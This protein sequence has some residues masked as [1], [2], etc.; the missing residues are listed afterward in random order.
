MSQKI[1]TVKIVDQL[2]TELN[3]ELKIDEYGDIN[4][5]IFIRDEI[6]YVDPKGH[7]LKKR[8]T[9]VLQG[10]IGCRKCT[11][12]YNIK[13]VRKLFSD[14]GCELLT[15]VY[16]DSKEQQFSYLCPN[17]H[18][19]TT[20]L[21]NF[22]HRKSYECEECRKDYY[23]NEI[24]KVARKRDYSIIELK[25]EN[26]NSLIE[27]MCSKNH[28]R[29]QKA[30]NFLKEH[31]C[32]ECI[33]YEKPPLKKVRKAFEDQGCLLLANN[34]INAHTSMKFLCRCGRLDRKTWST[35]QQGM[36]YC[37]KCR[38]ERYT[39]PSQLSY[40]EVYNILK[41]VGCKLLTKEYK[42][43]Q[44]Y[45]G[46]ECN[47]GN[48]DAK[49]LI[50]FRRGYRCGDCEKKKMWTEDNINGDLNDYLRKVVT[51]WKMDSYNEYGGRCAISQ[52][53]ANHIHHMYSFYKIVDE[54]F[55]EL[56][57][58]R[59]KTHKNYTDEELIVIKEKLLELHYKYGLGVPLSSNV[60][61]LLHSFYGRNVSKKDF[62]RFRSGYIML[63]K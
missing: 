57:L 10:H 44:S 17:R 6:T 58:P 13:S 23:K 24:I 50:L 46:Y 45:L 35:F 39:H 19:N 61:K 12:I 53:K 30:E 21:Y 8:L 9:K 26:Q 20:N 22:I 49:S 41:E 11:R 33:N 3:C 48:Y 15:N 42:N 32:L 37:R 56:N 1:Y 2:L 54:T 31:D 43:Q 47:C 7:L 60:H 55:N 40:D 59:Y 16:I 14:K 62:E 63:F 25:Y 36:Y 51:P 27:F 5:R 38:F 28:H 52:Q 29:F 4:Q 34:Y 18:E